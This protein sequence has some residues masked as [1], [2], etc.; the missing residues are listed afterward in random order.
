MSDRPR[1]LLVPE[2]TELTW[3]IRPQLEQWAEIGSYDPPG[4]G[5][6]PRRELS[7]ASIVERGIEEI[8]RLG[9]DRYFLAGDFWSNAA[10]A[11]IA[12]RRPGEVLGIALGHAALSSRHSG[13][14]PPVNP[15]VYSAFGQLIEQDAAA[16][17]RHGIVQATK[18]AIDERLATEMLER[19][20]PDLIKDGWHSLTREID[21]GEDLRELGVPLL[22]ARH[23]DCLM[24]TQ[25]GF[26]DAIAAFPQARVVVT[27][28]ACSSDE[29]FA[30]AMREFCAAVG[31]TRTVA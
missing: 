22:L 8:E 7:S 4:I 9:W 14:R 31:A 27:G 26:D 23:R 24:S 5:A 18:G 20:P 2:F 25:E 10:T 15:E 3:A 21:Y 19:I 17:I 16:F 12:R 29:A 1:I 13:E 11:K 30:E 28:A 6:E